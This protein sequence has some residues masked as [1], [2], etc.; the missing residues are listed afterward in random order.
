MELA[1][2]YTVPLSAINGLSHLTKLTMSKGA[3]TANSIRKFLNRPITFESNRIGRPL[4]FES[5]LEASQVPTYRALSAYV[6]AEINQR[7]LLAAEL[8]FRDYQPADPLN[9]LICSVNNL[10]K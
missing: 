8:C 2:L 10:H 4:E 1:S 7:C 5:N 9:V 6:W 3:D